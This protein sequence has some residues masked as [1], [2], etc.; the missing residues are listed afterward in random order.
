[1]ASEP[2]PFDPLSLAQGRP[3]PV[4]EFE[5]TPADHNAFRKLVVGEIRRAARTPAYYRTLAILI[6][7]VA[8]LVSGIVDF[9]LHL[10]TTLVV[11]VLFAAFWQLIARIYRRAADPL[12][13]GSL[14]GPRRVE[15][16][17]DGL[18]QTAPLHDVRTKWAGVLNIIETPTHVFLMTDRLAGYIVPRRAFRDEAHYTEFVRFARE[19]TRGRIIGS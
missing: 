2:T 6:A 19:R 17:E 8:V 3:A 14:V 12:A 10:P 5:V 13:N 7:A 4:V 9:D 1:M 16:D 11:V 18:R 15:L